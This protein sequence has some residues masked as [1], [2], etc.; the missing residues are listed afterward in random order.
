MQ[1]VDLTL[2]TT[3]KNVV[4][5]LVKVEGFAPTEFEWQTSIQDE[6]DKDYYAIT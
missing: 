2:V 1:K 6:H 4:L 5:A 3:Q